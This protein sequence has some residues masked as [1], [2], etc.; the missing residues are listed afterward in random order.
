LQKQKKKHMKHI[1]TPPV[2]LTQHILFCCHLC[3][4]LHAGAFIQGSSVL[5][6]A[7][8]N[9]AK[10]VLQHPGLY[11]RRHNENRMRKRM[12]HIVPSPM[13]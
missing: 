13:S 1:A 5:S 9:T 4:T 12:K 2:V 11:S 8:N 7:A 6:W 3:A 10:L